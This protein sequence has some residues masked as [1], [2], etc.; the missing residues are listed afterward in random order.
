M[1]RDRRRRLWCPAAI[2]VKNELALSARRGG[3]VYGERASGYSLATP[4]ADGRDSLAR[5]FVRLAL[6]AVR[7]FRE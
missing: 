3:A 4:G 2:A 6:G 7:L 5:V 1:K